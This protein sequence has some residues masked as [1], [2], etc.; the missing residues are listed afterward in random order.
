MSDVRYLTME[1]RE[2]GGKTESHADLMFCL[3]A[4]RRCVVAGGAGFDGIAGIC[5]A[6][7]QRGDFGGDQESAK[8]CGRDFQDDR[9]RAMRTSREHLAEFEAK[10]GVS[11]L[12]DIAAPLGGEVT[13]AFDGPVLPTPRWK[14]IVEVYDPA[15]LQSTIGK[16]VESFNREAKCAIGHMGSLQLTQ[17]QVGS[18]TYFTISSPRQANSEVDYTYVDNYLIAG[19]G[20]GHAVAGHSIARGGDIR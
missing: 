13:M 2:V 7:R 19:A 6:R 1:H 9:E 16:L 17:Q 18:R 14:L 20:Y 5:F 10:T 3:G 11:V 8:H 4:A 12:N 15:T